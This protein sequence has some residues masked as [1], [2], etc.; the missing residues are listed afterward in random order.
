MTPGQ[1]VRVKAAS[2]I[3]QRKDAAAGEL[4]TVLCCYTVHGRETSERVDVRFASNAILWG[5]AADQF[6][7]ADGA[8]ISRAS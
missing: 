5:V 1:R 6:E 3:A 4:G 2:P 8:E 7:P